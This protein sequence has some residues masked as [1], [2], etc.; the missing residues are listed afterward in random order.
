MTGGGGNL[1]GK[2]RQK[3]PN[4]LLNFLKAEFQWNWPS[5]APWPPSARNQIVI[6]NCPE[7]ILNRLLRA[8]TDWLCPICSPYSF[9]SLLVNYGFLICMPPHLTSPQLT[10]QT[11]LE[12]SNG[13]CCENILLRIRQQKTIGSLTLTKLLYYN[14]S[15]NNIYICMYLH[16][17]CS[18]NYL[19]IY[20]SYY[21]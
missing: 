13:L 10:M 8:M 17:H 3:W 18:I 1:K 12:R 9:L 19:Y 2:G 5:A 14:I 21:I 7:M 6:K 16:R 4:L 15:L 20:I 11:L